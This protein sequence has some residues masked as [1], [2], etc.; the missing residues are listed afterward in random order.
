[1][2]TTIAM[3]ATAAISVSL[4]PDEVVVVETTPLVVPVLVPVGVVV[5][6][7]GEVEVGVRLTHAV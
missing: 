1:M 5:V 4:D 3:I 6:V 2:I 7:E